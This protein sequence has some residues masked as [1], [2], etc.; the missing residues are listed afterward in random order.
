MGI[1]GMRIHICSTLR[2]GES[3]QRTSI[4]S[5]GEIA[6]RGHLIALGGNGQKV[7]GVYSGGG[8]RSFE[9]QSGISRSNG[10]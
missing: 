4:V 9:N 6:W 2:T 10:K 8:C 5:Q 3:F 7:Q 1:S